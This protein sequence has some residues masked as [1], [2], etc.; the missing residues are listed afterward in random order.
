MNFEPETSA[1]SISKHVPMRSV[2]L[3]QLYASEAYRRGVITDAAVDAADVEMPVLLTTMLCEAVER[4]LTRELSVGFSRRA[5]TLHRVRGKID[6]YA[7][8]RHRLLDKGQIR[9]EFNELTSDHPVNRFLLHALHYAEKLIQPLDTT[10]ATRCRRLARAFE[11]AGVPSVPSTAEPTGRLS[12][13]DAHP[14]AVASLLLNLY[15]PRSGLGPHAFARAAVT[16]TYLRALFERALLG[17]Y[18]YHLAPLG[19]TVRGAKYVDWPIN[20]ATTAQLPR[21]LTDI[22]LTA[23]DGTEVIVD[24]KFASMATSNRT[25]SGYTL[26]SGHLY[27]IQS[28]VLSHSAALTEYSDFRPVAGVMV[29]ADLGAPAAAFDTI[30]NFR[31]H[32]H[33]FVFGALDLTTRASKIRETALTM[34]Q[35]LKHEPLA[36]N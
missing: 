36:L 30:Q 16:E 15:V 32:N 24:A 14:T 8:Q 26:K 27:Q 35:S 10:V 4:R 17:I 34:I 20:E 25:N 5:A 6:V 33:D 19:W 12:P 18:R 11:A 1:E 3:L 21:M 2:W 9:C 29:Y 22:M 13:A 23:P 28:Y 7:T 31:M